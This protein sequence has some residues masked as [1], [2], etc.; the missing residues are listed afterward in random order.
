MGCASDDQSLNEPVAYTASAWGAQTRNATPDSCGSAPIP[1]RDFPDA[2]VDTKVLRPKLLS[3]SAQPKGTRSWPV[4]FI[5]H[6]G[7]RRLPHPPSRPTT[8]DHPHHDDQDTGA[9]EGDD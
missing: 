9:D 5:N 7:E 1:A 3:D 8:A 6:I 4:R 2:I